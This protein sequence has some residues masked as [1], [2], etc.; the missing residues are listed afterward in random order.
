MTISP[1]LARALSE[2]A[3][4]KVALSIVNGKRIE[5]AASGSAIDC[6]PLDPASA[7][8]MHRPELSSPY[9][10]YETYITDTTVEEGDILTVNSR[11]YAVRAVDD[12]KS[13]TDHLLHLV[14]EDEQSHA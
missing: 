8:T 3:T 5:A 4:K 10:K 12:F 13:G 1:T 14:L 7:E 11:D 9:R 2:R 6:A